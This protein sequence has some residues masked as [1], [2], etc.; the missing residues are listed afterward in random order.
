MLENILNNKINSREDE[1]TSTIIGLLKYLPSE[2]FWDILKN[3]CNDSSNLPKLSGDIDFISFWNKW[4][5]EKTTNKNYVE[6]DVF[7]QF[8]E[9]DLIIETRCAL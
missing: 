1:I 6:P 5:A 7:I 2:L 3:A 9:F 8:S 4:G